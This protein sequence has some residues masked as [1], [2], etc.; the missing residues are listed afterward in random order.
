MSDNR[1]KKINELVERIKSEDESAFEEFYKVLYPEIY[2]FIFRNTFDQIQSE[3]ISQETFIRF[4]ESRDQV[5]TDRHP[6][7]YLFKI[8]KN[9]LINSINRKKKIY[10]LDEDFIENMLGAG[11]ISENMLEHD[12]KKAILKLPEKCRLIFLLNRF[13]NFRY[14]EIAE[15]LDISLQTVKNQMSKSIK[16]IREYLES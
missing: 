1:T 16:L 4:W 2:G 7:A 8:A 5:S 12:L 6:K 15:I 11:E 3:E 9:L 10:S 13:H 14:A